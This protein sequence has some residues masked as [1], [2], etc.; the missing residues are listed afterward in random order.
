MKTMMCCGRTG[1]TDSGPAPELQTA[2][3]RL[4]AA[5]EKLKAA[6]STLKTPVP[7]A[8]SLAEEVDAELSKPENRGLFAVVDESRGTV[9]TFVAPVPYFKQRRT[10]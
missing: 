5:T 9:R 7:S 10:E 8:P 2:T 1:R 3:T 4:V 6:A